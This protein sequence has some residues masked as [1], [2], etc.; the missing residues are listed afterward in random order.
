LG[1]AF[2][3]PHIGHLVLAQEA[4]SQLGLERVLLVPAGD[5]PHKRIDPEP[6]PELRL[7]MTR[8]A[9]EG[10]ELLEVSPIE[11][12]RAG[13]SYTFRTLEL[14]RDRWPDD[15]LTFL[16]GAD[17]AAHLDEWREP[18][19]VVELARLGIAARPGTVLDEAEATLERLGATA[20][21]DLIRMPEIGV[22]STWIRRRVAAGRPVRHL[23]PDA[24]AE[25]IAERGLY[26]AA[27]T[28]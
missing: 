19:R 16:M 17:V 7:E 20:R 5:A 22:S 23:V 3:P 18:A 10:D 27:V 11:V 8:L 21:A 12:E 13:P 15:E 25:L 28:A 1:G 26:G 6:G 24:V 4:A 14:L 2:N 9:A